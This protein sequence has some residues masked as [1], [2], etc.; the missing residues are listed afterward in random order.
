MKTKIKLCP[1][2]NYK[3]ANLIIKKGLYCVKCDRQGSRFCLAEGPIRLT[4]WGAIKAWNR[5][6]KCK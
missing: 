6:P 5:R 1:F 2:C 3:H 4:K